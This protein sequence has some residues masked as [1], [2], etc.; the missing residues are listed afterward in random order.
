MVPPADH[1]SRTVM[2]GQSDLCLVDLQTL[3]EW[4]VGKLKV[5]KN[6]SGHQPSLLFT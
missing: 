2:M 6:Q 1:M 5:V 4:L 3:V